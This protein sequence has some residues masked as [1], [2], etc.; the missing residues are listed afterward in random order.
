MISSVIGIIFLLIIVGILWWA[1]TEL[2]ALLPLPSAI[3]RAIY[4]LGVVLI[5]LLVIYVIIVIL[6]IVGIH[7]SIPKV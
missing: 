3:Q 2:I 6:G 7:V 5:A 1:V 4:I